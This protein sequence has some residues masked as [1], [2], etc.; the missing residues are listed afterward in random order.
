MPSTASTT[1][2]ESPTDADRCHAP[3]VPLA[4]W[5]RMS[6]RLVVLA[7]IAGC[8]APPAPRRP[9]PTAKLADLDDATRSEAATAAASE[10][11]CPRIVHPRLWAVERDGKTSYLY[12][13]YH[14]GVPAD[15]LPDVVTDA[16]LAATTIG[17]ESVDDDA[18]P[19]EDPTRG[20][21]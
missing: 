6:H 16:F 2:W 8:A 7:V 9:V 11:A 14:V 12:G 17:F 19:L 1:R 15:R 21:L 13:T 20:T 4:R 10:R 18:A 3:P 5:G